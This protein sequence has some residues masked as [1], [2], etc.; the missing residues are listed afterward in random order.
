M[1]GKITT[2]IA[3]FLTF[4]GPHHLHRGFPVTARDGSQP[5]RD[6][7]GR[8][9][10]PIRGNLILPLMGPSTLLIVDFGHRVCFAMRWVLDGLASMLSPL[11]RGFSERWTLAEPKP[12]VNS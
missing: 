3:P 7:H 5:S 11:T 6:D 12:G 9:R 8:R 4:P 1:S 2:P 10:A